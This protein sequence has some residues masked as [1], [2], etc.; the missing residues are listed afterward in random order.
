MAETVSLTP[1]QGGWTLASEG[2]ASVA[3]QV[4]TSGPVIVHVGQSA[5][6]LSAPG[7]RIGTVNATEFRRTGL[8]LDDNV[9]LRVADDAPRDTAAVVVIRGS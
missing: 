4:Q 6:A 5:P 8:G 9:Y 1:T 3:I 7:W 2:Q